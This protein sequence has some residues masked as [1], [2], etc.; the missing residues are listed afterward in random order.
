M[1]RNGMRGAVRLV[2][3]L[4]LTLVIWPGGAFQ[5]V[6][7]SATV[8][9]TATATTSR[10]PALAT[11]LE[12]A[13]QAPASTES[14]ATAWVEQGGGTAARICYA[15]ALYHG[16]QYEKAATRLEWLI[17][18]AVRDRRQP[19]LQLYIWAGWAWLRAG[20]PDQ[21]EALY[22]AALQRRPNDLDLRMDRALARVEAEKFWDA[23]SDLNEVTR[24]APHRADGWY[25]RALAQRGLLQ[26]E[27]ALR[28]AE[29]A[30]AIVPNDADT[31]LLRGNL[32]AQT[33]RKAEALEDWRQIQ[34]EAPDSNA[35]RAAAANVR[36]LPAEVEAAGKG[37][38]K[39][40]SHGQENDVVK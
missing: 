35:G 9:T 36:R 32:R 17:E 15:M 3:R 6:A 34:R 33:G 13:R 24:L 4:C 16:G 37:G 8:A 25:Y 28:D 12:Q 20:K 39:S 5:A 38:G 11:C 21:A 22:S 27:N 1:K 19:E 30:L 23:L 31:R 10:D 14:T 40:E 2:Q 29:R 7:G 26:F 18:E